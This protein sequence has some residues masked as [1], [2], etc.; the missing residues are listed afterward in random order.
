M[1]RHL[2]DSLDPQAKQR[3]VYVGGTSYYGHQGQTVVD[4]S[5]TPKPKGWGPYIAPAIEALDADMKRGLQI[6]VAFPAYIY[7]EGYSW[8]RQYVYDK[9]AAGQKVDTL[10][11]HPRSGTFMHVEDCARAII[12]LL[13]HGAAGERYF[14]AGNDQ[15]NW[16]TFN[17]TVARLMQVPLKVRKAPP[18]LL[19]LF[20]GP[21]GADTIDT[22]SWLSN[23]KL[24][25]TGFSVKYANIE[26]GLSDVVGR[27]RAARAA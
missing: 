6:V 16:V 17:E 21:I 3:I 20:M 7:G 19:R 14:V 11:G 18:W 24:Q 22:E 2:L 5:V 8:F 4:E 9:I 23:R 27:L 25:A 13:E 15:T 10:S 1:D 12:H 26:A